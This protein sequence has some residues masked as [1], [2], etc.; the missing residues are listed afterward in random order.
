MLLVSFG[1]ARTFDD[2]PPSV[3]GVQLPLEEP[4]TIAGKE[5]L[6][7]NLYV[8]NHDPSLAPEGKTVVNFFV[9]PS[10][11]TRISFELAEKRLV[12]SGRVLDAELAASLRPFAAK[13]LYT[14]EER[15]RRDAAQAA[16]RDIDA[17]ADAAT[18]VAPGAVGELAVIQQVSDLDHHRSG[19]VGLGHAFLL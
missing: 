4:L 9:E 15:R 8:Y 14:E 18:D 5:R 17:I 2:P 13:T 1:V 3:G 7:V 6:N 16:R 12:I 10:T 19:V 11:R